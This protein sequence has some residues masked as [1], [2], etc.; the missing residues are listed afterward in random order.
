VNN[1][2]DALPFAV[3]YGIHIHVVIVLM[4]VAVMMQQAGLQGACTHVHIYTA[5]ITCLCSRG[6][7][8]A[9]CL[10]LSLCM[11]SCVGPA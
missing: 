1:N 2:L 7:Q 9:E 11:W 3:A 4:F 10:Y 8:A 5:F 6:E